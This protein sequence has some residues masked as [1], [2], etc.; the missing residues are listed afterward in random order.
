MF[1]IANVSTI[2]QLVVARLK[3]DE[4]YFLCCCSFLFLLT[5][6]VCQN[7]WEGTPFHLRINNV[8]SQAKY[9]EHNERKKILTSTCG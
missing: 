7:S 3:T 9:K 8:T 1:L 6:L 5:G 2:L 4:H